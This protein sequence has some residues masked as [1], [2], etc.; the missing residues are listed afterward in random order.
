M[1]TMHITRANQGQHFLVG[2]DVLTIKAG[3]DMTS[4]SMLVFEIC[5]LPGD[6]P[7][8]L[9]RHG[10]SEVF[11]L[12]SGEFE[13]STLDADNHLQTATLKAGDTIAIPSMAWHNFKN[14]GASTGRFLAI[15]SPP[16]MEELIYAIGVPVDNPLNPPRP[17]EPPSA[18]ERQRFMSLI[19]QYM[20][21]LPPDAIAR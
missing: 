18:E 15:H 13:I 8:T 12:L 21:M 4:G 6:G 5:V 2:T 9:H 16:V 19:G 20:E 10:Y 14:V 11:Y 1:N 7:P 17:A 3:R